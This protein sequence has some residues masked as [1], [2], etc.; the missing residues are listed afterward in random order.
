MTLNIQCPE[1]SIV[2]VYIFPVSPN[3]IL[4]RD[5]LRTVE[6]KAT[7]LGIHLDMIRAHGVQNIDISF[8]SVFIFAV[9][10]YRAYVV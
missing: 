8:H 10:I 3:I 9:R 4:H 7:T 1:I 6:I 5:S 2:D